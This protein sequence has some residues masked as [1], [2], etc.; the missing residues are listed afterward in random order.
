MFAFV[1]AQILVVVLASA[2]GRELRIEDEPL[3]DAAAKLAE[4]TDERLRAAA[5][6]KPLPDPPLFKADLVTARIAYVMA[7]VNAV[8]L[9]GIA[10]YA[11]S[12]WRGSVLRALQMHRYTFDRVWKPA[13]V[14]IGGY[15]LVVVYTIIVSVLDLDFIQPAES[16]PGSITRD[17]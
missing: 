4:Y 10:L 16:I 13:L 14:T 9:A 15:V 1:L 6:G 8:A 5:L 17:P 11:M 3:F 12:R 7:V 2:L